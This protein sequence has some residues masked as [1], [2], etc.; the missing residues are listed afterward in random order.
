MSQEALAPA[1]VP[2]KGPTIND[3]VPDGQVNLRFL[4]VNGN[5]TDLLVLPTDTFE[6]VRKRIFEQ[7]PTDWSDGRPLAPE[8]LK[9]LYHGA[10]V[11]PT[12]PV[13]SINPPQGQT[14]TVHLL[15]RNE[16]PAA[17]NKEAPA[18]TGGDGAVREQ[19]SS[20]CKCIIL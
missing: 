12:S 16:A 19:R 5:K 18:A 1:S 9:I 8:N 17:E 3:K 14:T 10:F 15:V 2:P 20:G 13:S 7:W 11:Q 4:L 6:V